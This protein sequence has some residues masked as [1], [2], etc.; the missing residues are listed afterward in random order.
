MEITITNFIYHYYFIVFNK[1][2]TRGLGAGV[3]GFWDVVGGYYV[4]ANVN[5]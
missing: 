5:N 1:F 3:V 2:L 4:H